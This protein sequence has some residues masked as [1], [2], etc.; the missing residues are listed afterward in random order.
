MPLEV[1]LPGLRSDTQCYLCSF[2]TCSTKSTAAKVVAPDLV[3]T[4]V[5]SILAL[6]NLDMDG[7]C[8]SGHTSLSSGTAQHEDKSLEAS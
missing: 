2:G 8:R 7:R 1:L 6:G 3:P 4:V 5:G